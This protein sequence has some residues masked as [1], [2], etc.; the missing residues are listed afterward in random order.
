[1]CSSDLVIEREVAR[2]VDVGGLTIE[3]RADRIDQFPDGTFGILDYKTTD[4]LSTKDWDG[5]RPAAPQLPLYVV[6]SER[7]ISAVHY[8]QLM[9]GDVEMIGYAGAEVSARIDHWKRV[10]EQLGAGFVR[11]EAAVNPKD[12][13]KTCEFCDLT[14]LCRI[15]ESRGA[16]GGEE[17]GE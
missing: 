5:E 9:P 8:A 14:A 11:G 15:G 13:R 4:N 6:M 2:K 10:I 12:P 7:Q 3:I 16:A 17:D 1:M